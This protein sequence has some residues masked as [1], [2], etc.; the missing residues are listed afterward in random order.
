MSSQRRHHQGCICGI[1]SCEKQFFNEV[2]TQLIGGNSCLDRKL[3]HLW[4]ERQWAG[5]KGE[6][7]KSVFLDQCNFSLY[8]KEVFLCPQ[9]SASLTTYQRNFV[10]QMMETFADI[11]HWSKCRP[12]TKR[13]T[14]PTPEAQA[15]MKEM[16]EWLESQTNRISPCGNCLSYRKMYCERRL[17]AQNTLRKFLKLTRFI[18]IPALKYYASSEDYWSSLSHKQTAKKTPAA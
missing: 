15:T 16:E 7:T 17:T 6:N 3:T 18:R 8:S 9:K 4:L 14:K 2:K 1:L 11:F 12:I 13:S 5:C 10:L